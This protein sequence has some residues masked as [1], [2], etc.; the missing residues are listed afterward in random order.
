M[1]R[2]FLLT[3]MLNPGVKGF[4]GFGQEIFLWRNQNGKGA[5]DFGFPTLA[6]P[7]RVGHPPNYASSM[8]SANGPF[9]EN[10]R[11]KVTF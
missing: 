11:S 9:A 8:C 7:A 3:T 10:V 5:D 4:R 2:R 1:E 6:K